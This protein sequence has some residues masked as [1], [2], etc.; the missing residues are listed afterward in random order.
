MSFEELK[1]ALRDLLA[2]VDDFKL[3]SLDLE[4]NEGKNLTLK[5]EGQKFYDQNEVN[6]QLLDWIKDNIPRTKQ[7]AHMWS[8]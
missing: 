2:L 3:V 5:K 8:G 4:V 1:A 6:T 7:T